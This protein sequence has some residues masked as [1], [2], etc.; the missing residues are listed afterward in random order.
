[1]PH[2]QRREGRIVGGGRAIH[3]GHGLERIVVEAQHHVAGEAGA[4]GAL[5]VGAQRQADCMQP[6]IGAA[7][8]VGYRKAVAADPDLASSDHG[9]ADAAGSDDDDAAVFGAMRADA[10]DGRVMGVDDRAERMRVLREF[11]GSAFA[12]DPGKADGGV[13]GAERV[14]AEAGFLDRGAAG[15]FHF[16]QRAVDAEPQRGR[17]GNAGPEQ[18]SFGVLDARAAA[19]AATVNADEQRAGLC[20]RRHPATRWISAPHCTSLR[21]SDS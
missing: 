8:L 19:G 2:H 12:A 4:D 9:K 15:L 13:H 18:A 7:A 1:M 21:S 20:S 11:L 10:G 14:G 17:A 3:P 16:G 5:V 6:E